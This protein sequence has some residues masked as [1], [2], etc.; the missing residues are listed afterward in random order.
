[1]DDYDDH[2]IDFDE[3][4]TPSQ[5]QLKLLL[6]IALGNEPEENFYFNSIVNRNI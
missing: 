4:M 3:V 6:D 5:W 1:M 2:P